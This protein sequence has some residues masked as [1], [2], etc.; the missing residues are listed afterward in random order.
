MLPQAP[1]Q[2]LYPPSMTVPMEEELT[3]LGVVP[4][5]TAEEVDQAVQNNPFAVIIVNSVCGCAAGNARPAIAEVISRVPKDAQIKW[6]TVFAGVNRE[7]TDRARYYT[8]AIAP[9]SP[10]IFLIKKEYVVSSIS[11]FQIEGR[12]PASVAADLMRGLREYS[13]ESFGKE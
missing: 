6:F 3:R 7:A 4:L 12:T 10:S 2:P 9:S 1:L 5:R 11:R 13:P 8:R